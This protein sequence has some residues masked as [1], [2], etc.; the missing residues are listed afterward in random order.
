MDASTHIQKLS[1]NIKIKHKTLSR[2]YIINCTCFRLV[3]M[4]KIKLESFRG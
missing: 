4:A 2:F 1:C 3:K